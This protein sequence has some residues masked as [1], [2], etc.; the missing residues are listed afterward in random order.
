M[1][2]QKKTTAEK[3]EKKTPVK[4]RP[5]A[6]KHSG[7]ITEPWAIM[8]RLIAEVPGFQPL[9]VA[10]V[11]LF[12]ARDWKADVDGIA[13]GA[14]VCKASEIDRN[15]VEETGGETPDV[16]IKLPETQWPTLDETEKEHRL[17]HELCHIKAAKNA[18]GDQKR[19]AKDRLLWRMARH[20]IAAFHEEIE[21][22]GINRV[23]EHNGRI[24]RAIEDA[25]RPLLANL[26]QRAAQVRGEMR[27]W[28][29]QDLEVLQT[30]NPKITTKQVEK[31]EDAGI[32]TLGALAKHMDR[33]GTTWAKGFRFGET[34]R[35]VIEDVL[36]AI[37]ATASI[38][39]QPVEPAEVA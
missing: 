15:L 39:L 22:Y 20:P 32:P 37:R 8:E 13:T 19:D 7:K 2:R 12:W 33:M 30:R 29:Q 16:F 1:G 6:R 4:L 14:Q 34:T 9:R 10:H 38:E 28:Q 24:I 18:N 26:E 11:K 5:I 25:D 27:E 36:G 23:I 21:R 3:Q 35:Q 31:L 17:F